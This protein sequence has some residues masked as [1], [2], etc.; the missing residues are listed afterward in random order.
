MENKIKR[1]TRV[2]SKFMKVTYTQE[3]AFTVKDNAMV[4]ITLI[5]MLTF[6]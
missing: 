2:L 6:Y 4:I 3:I 1:Q 5:I